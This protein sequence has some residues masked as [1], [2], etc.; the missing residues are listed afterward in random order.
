MRAKMLL[1]IAIII[2]SD[3]Y[4]S[5][6]CRSLLE[7]THQCCSYPGCEDDLF[8]ARA[9]CTD[10]TK[11]CVRYGLRKATVVGKVLADHN[12]SNTAKDCPIKSFICLG[13]LG[14]CSCCVLFAAQA[15]CY[16]MVFE[17][18]AHT[19]SCIR[20]FA[21]YTESRAHELHELH[22]Q[23]LKCFMCC[24]GTGYMSLGL[25]MLAEEQNWDRRVK[26]WATSDTVY[27]KP[28]HGTEDAVHG[29]PE[30]TA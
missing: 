13:G 6:L 2:S 1:Y 26:H 15:I 25:S 11:S 14:A 7:R 9:A 18:C 3:L 19:P 30:E 24:G 22:L 4:S 17:I 12:I 10:C 29:E 28:V 8:N 16:Q 23:S 27:R 21:A 20:T 5:E